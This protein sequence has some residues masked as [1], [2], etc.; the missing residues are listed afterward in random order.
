MLKRLYI[1]NPDPVLKY[2]VYLPYCKQC[3][4][5]VQ[6]IRIEDRGAEFVISAF[7]H[8]KEEQFSVP[9]TWQGLHYLN[10]TIENHSWFEV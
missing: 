5:Q 7:C 6:D 4:R 8:D 2:D 3:K 1:R 9:A 10:I